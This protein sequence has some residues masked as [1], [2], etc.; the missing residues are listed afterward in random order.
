MSIKK[1][2]KAVLPLMVFALLL[3]ACAPAAAAATIIAT[4]NGMPNLTVMMALT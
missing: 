2:F 4:T 1:F 3:A